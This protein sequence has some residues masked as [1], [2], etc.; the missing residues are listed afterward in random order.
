MHFL[1][2]KDSKN[3]PVEFLKQA[4]IDAPLRFFPL[5]QLSSHSCRRFFLRPQTIFKFLVFIT[6]L[7][8]G[9]SLSRPHCSVKSLKFGSD[10]THSIL[11]PVGSDHFS[12]RGLLHA[13]PFGWDGSLPSGHENLQ[14][15]PR[16]LASMADETL[17]ALITD[18]GFASQIWTYNCLSRTVPYKHLRI[19]CLTIFQRISLAACVYSETILFSLCFCRM[20]V[21][22]SAA[23]VD[24]CKKRSI[25]Y[26]GRWQ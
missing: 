8:F 2:S 22:L 16:Q 24:R 5:E 26:F 20:L 15:F 17:K 11:V 14:N 19:A 13:I 3:I 6:Q 10:R 18:L 7:D 1:S 12:T 4:I 25:V 23:A 21:S 9:W